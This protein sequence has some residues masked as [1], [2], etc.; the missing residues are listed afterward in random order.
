MAEVEFCA[1]C[2]V[3]VH[4]H[5]DKPHDARTLRS[6]ETMPHACQRAVAKALRRVDYDAVTRNVARRDALI[7]AEARQAAL[8]RA[9]E[10][11]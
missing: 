3:A 4:L 2:G 11:R 5:D 1:R 7:R 6:D 9:A 8:A 10:S